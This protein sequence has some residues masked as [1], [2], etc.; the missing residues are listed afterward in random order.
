MTINF[1][2][3]NFNGVGAHLYLY[4]GIF[5]DD[6]DRDYLLKICPPIHPN[7]YVDHVTLQFKPSPIDVMKMDHWTDNHGEHTEI[8]VTHIISNAKA[9]VAR[10]NIPQNYE[11]GFPISEKQIPH[12]TISCAE[13]VSPSYSNTLLKTYID[14]GASVYYYPWHTRPVLHGRFA[15]CSQLDREGL[16]PEV[17]KRRGL[18][19]R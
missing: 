4:T 12:M 5:L 16:S 7:V 17:L 11:H 1:K 6:K 10:I 8:I 15:I 9:Q 2:G 19:V 18:T 3:F 14:T 13:G